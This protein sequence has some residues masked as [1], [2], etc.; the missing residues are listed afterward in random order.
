MKNKILLFGLG[1]YMSV[2]CAQSNTE[3]FLMDLEVKDGNISFSS[4]LNISNN[5]GYDNQPSFY[6]DNLI[7]FASTRNGQTD[8]AKYNVRDKVI[9]W[10]SNTTDGGEYSP[11]KIPNTKEISAIRLDT[12]GTQL[13]YRYNLDSGNPRTV[14]KGLKVG[15]HVWHKPTVLVASVLVEDRMDLVVSNLKDNSNRT[16]QQKVGRS[17]HKIPNTNLVSYISKEQDSWEIKSLNP[18]SG[19]TKKIGTMLPQVEDMCWLINGSILSAKGSKLYKYTPGKDSDWILVKDFKSNG[20]DNITRIT[21]NAISSK[22][23]IVAEVSLEQLINKQVNSFNA[24]DLSAFVSCFAPNVLVKRFPSDTMYVGRT[25]MRRRYQQFYDNVET[26]KVAVIN[27]MVLGSVVVDE[28]LD[29]TDGAKNHQIAIYETEENFILSMTFIFSNK[30]NSEQTKTIVQKQL[31]AYNAK[32]IDA[33]MATYSDDIKLYRY[34]DQLFSEGKQAMREGYQRFFETT[35]NLNAAIRN[36][37]I[38][39]NK[40][41][42]QEWVTA[43]DQSFGAIAIYEVTEGKISKVTFIQ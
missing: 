18:V 1:L 10:V 7:L 33:F 42:D 40:I 26:P 23:A 36:R 21:T 16:F 8:I 38:I 31:D 25:E 13:L 32:D 11:L 19:A 3:V 17:L 27:R 20:I 12:D 9:S 24:K 15:Y 4:P 43:N 41:I 6:N 29:T 30:G 28:E 34:P 5:P 2:A 14:V 22:I 35:P 39:G 37:M